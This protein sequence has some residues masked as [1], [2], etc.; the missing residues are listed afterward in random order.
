MRNAR[1]ARGRRWRIRRPSSESCLLV[2][3]G[4]RSNAALCLRPRERQA[5]IARVAFQLTG[6]NSMHAQGHSA[7]SGG[8]FSLLL[9]NGGVGAR[10]GGGRPKQLITINGLP[11]LVYS[12][13]AAHKI[14]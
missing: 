9:L 10:V 11:I 7:P 8:R 4:R 6:K 1:I 12:L 2:L 14:D 5:N 3:V 13:V